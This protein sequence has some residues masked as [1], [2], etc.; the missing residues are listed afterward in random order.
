MFD[1]LNS[2]SNASLAE[3]IAADEARVADE[4]GALRRRSWIERAERRRGERAEDE[5]VALDRD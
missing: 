3:Q 2:A 4:R 1:E 5:Q